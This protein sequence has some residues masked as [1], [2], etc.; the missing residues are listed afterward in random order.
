VAGLFAV[1]SSLFISRS[2]PISISKY[3]I[4]QPPILVAVVVFAIAIYD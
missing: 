1:S 2:N 3:V 4:V